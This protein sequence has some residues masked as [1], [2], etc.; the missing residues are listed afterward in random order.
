VAHAPRPERAGNGA[1]GTL[2]QQEGDT[3]TL[4]TAGKIGG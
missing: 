2:A 1:R 4:P 3:A